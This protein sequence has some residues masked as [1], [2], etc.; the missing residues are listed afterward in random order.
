MGDGAIPSFSIYQKLNTGSSTKAELVGI[1]DT[2][3]LM[4]WTKY[5]MEEKGFIISSDVLF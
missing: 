4:M 3:G 1:S 5:F 2:I